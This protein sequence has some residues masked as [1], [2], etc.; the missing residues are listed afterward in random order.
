MMAYESFDLIC[1]SAVY[2][3]KACT[4]NKLGDSEELNEKNEIALGIRKA[5]GITTINPY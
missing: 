1:Q 4:T 5:K 2:K 3:C